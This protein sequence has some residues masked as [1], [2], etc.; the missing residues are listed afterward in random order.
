MLK[1]LRLQLTAWY[2]AFFSVLLLLLCVLL[3]GALARS[4]QRR[5][6]ASLTMQA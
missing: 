5:L 4:M 3:Y 1:S 6:D 2:L